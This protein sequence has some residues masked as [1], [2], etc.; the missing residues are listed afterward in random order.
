[1]IWQWYGIFYV[2][3]ND[4]NAG[5]PSGNCAAMNIRQNADLGSM[6]TLSLPCN[7]SYFC[8][9][10]D[11]C[12]LLQAVAWAQ[13]RKLPVV[14]LGE[15]SNV[16]LPVQLDALVLQVAMHGYLMSRV[17]PDIIDIAAGTNWHQL[18]TE[19]LASG[20]YGLENLALIPGTVGA[21]PVQNIGA[22]GVEIEHFI[23]SVKVLDTRTLEWLEM[24]RA[25]CEF[26]YRHS[27]FREHPQRFIITRVRLRLSRKMQVN[28]TY[29]ALRAELDR[30][31]IGQA[32][33]V[34]VYDAVVHIRQQKLPDPVRQANAG[35][36][37][38]NPLV[39]QDHYLQL[40]QQYPELVAY[41]QSDGLVKLAAGWLIEQAGFKGKIVKGVCMHPRQALVLVNHSSASAND[42]LEYADA[43]VAKVALLFG[44]GLQREPLV[45]GSD[46]LC[47][48]A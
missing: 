2:T 9:A 6:N 26:G 20:W 48:A 27:I 15:G 24:H 14:V 5:S 4:Q 22:Y 35:S 40:L 19:L 7:T 47:S 33:A 3:P 32:T 38:K 36:F 34:D 1:M 12:E 16:V 18:V 45:V 44:V 25:D 42:V 10:T 11:E 17:E 29:G 28:D 39:T 37:F 31:G 23:D 8:A 43:I 21:A 30:R 13:Q 46:G 41:P